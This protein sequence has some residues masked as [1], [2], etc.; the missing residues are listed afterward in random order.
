MKYFFFQ[1]E[2]EKEKK[3]TFE[4]VRFAGPLCLLPAGL[5][6]SLKK[7]KATSIS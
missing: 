4:D 2:K 5:G 7:Q 6:F 1:G 3:E